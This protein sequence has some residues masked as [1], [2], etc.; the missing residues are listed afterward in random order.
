MASLGF[1]ASPTLL[2]GALLVVAAVVYWL[3]VFFL[4]YH[5]IR[6]GIG[7]W[8]KRLAILFF[9]GSAVMFLAAVAA[10]ADVSWSDLGDTMSFPIFRTPSL[11]HFSPPVHP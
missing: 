6:F 9:F 8:P 10:A 7:Y 3:N 2:V 4:L 1:S 11:P 5:L